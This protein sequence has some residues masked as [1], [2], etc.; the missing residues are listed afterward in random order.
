M[1]SIT[2]I[3]PNNFINAVANQ[4][5]AKLITSLNSI[6]DRKVNFRNNINTFHFPANPPL[7]ANKLIA[8]SDSKNANW[9]TEIQFTPINS[10][11][12]IIYDSNPEYLKQREAWF[13]SFPNECPSPL[14]PVGLSYAQNLKISLAPDQSN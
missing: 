13:A 11:N 3:F 12:A 14:N 8:S 4:N 7:K 1:L 5:V 9:D 10:L 2:I 6:F